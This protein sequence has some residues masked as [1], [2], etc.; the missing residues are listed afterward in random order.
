[1]IVMAAWQKSNPCEHLYMNTYMCIHVSAYMNIY[2]FVSN[3]CDSIFIYTYIYIYTYISLSLY[4]P[5]IRTGRAKVQPVREYIYICIHIY[6]CI[7][8]NLSFITKRRVNPQPSSLRPALHSGSSW[9]KRKSSRCA[10]VYVYIQ[11][12]PPTPTHTHT[13]I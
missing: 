7:F 3:L 9:R 11:P 4:K 2:P 8:I 10:R 13:H 5:L 6:I 1:M 12:H